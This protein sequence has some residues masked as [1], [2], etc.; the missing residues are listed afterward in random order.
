MT[1]T[2][3][4]DFSNPTAS[5]QALAAYQAAGL[6]TTAVASATTTAGAGGSGSAP[7]TL[8]GNG[9]TLAHLGA[10]SGETNFV[11]GL[12]SQFLF[13]GQGANIL[14]YLAV[15]DGGDRVSAFDPAKD[16]IDLS[17][18]DADITTPG[19]QNFTFIGDAP[20]SGGAQVR[21]Q[22]DPTND[23]TIVQAALAGDVTADFTIT[24]AGLA[25]LTA[26]NFA[27]TPS[28]SSAAL[29]AGA[30]LTYSKVATAARRADRIC[31]FQRS[32]QSL[33]VVRIVLWLRIRK[34]CGG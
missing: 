4:V 1:G 25:P 8:L 28:Q 17:R 18:I 26:A 5:T 29:A 30:A 10:A 6:P 13:G 34:P 15:G 31:I 24:L 2:T 23:V 11:G 20:F 19:L 9:I 22:L 12:G 16:V 7:T 27:L 33:C 14:T 21:Y 3:I 32:R